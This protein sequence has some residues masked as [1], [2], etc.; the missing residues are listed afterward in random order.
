[1]SLDT[2]E[3]TLSA[4]SQIDY[5]VHSRVHPLQSFEFPE[6]EAFIKRDD[7]LGFGISGSKIRKYRTLIPWLINQK[8]EEVCLLG[9]ASSNHIL[10]ICQLLIEN[11]IKPT[12]FLRG[13]PEYSLKGNCLLSSMFVPSERIHWFSKDEWKHAPRT[14]DRY[15]ASSSHTFVMPEGG[16]TSASLGGALTLPLDILKNE[17]ELGAAFDHIF[18]DAGTGFTASSLIM[19]LSLLQSRAQIHTVLLAG[20]PSS[21]HALLKESHQDLSELMHIRSPFPDNFTL[22]LPQLTGRF[23]STS[24]SIF[25]FIKDTARKEGFLTDPVYSAKLLIEGREILSKR[26]LKGRILFI[27]SG[28]GTSLLGFQEQLQRN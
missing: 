12:L 9:S 17:R 18:I 5:P 21:F 13:N 16:A 4:I 25:N 10:G 2:L 20:T 24:P 26:R 19:G 8:F 6:V 11:H 28:G 7:E 15:A 1:M 22:H 14:A 23:G 27:H 3:K